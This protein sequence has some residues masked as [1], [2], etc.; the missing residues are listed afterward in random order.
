MEFPVKSLI[1]PI[2]IALAAIG[3]ST[4]FAAEDP[5]KLKM[6]DLEARLIRIERVIENQSLIQLAAEVDT[7]H[8]KR[9]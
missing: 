3:C 5:M 6:V 1:T 7:R 4:A 2:A 8:P 9:F